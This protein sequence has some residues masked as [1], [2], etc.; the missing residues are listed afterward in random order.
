M[1]Q[2]IKIM[3]S[4]PSLSDDEIRSY[5]DF[6][7][8]LVKQKAIGTKKSLWIKSAISILIIGGVATTSF[9]IINN[10]S[11]KQ[12]SATAID[13]STH[14]VPKDKGEGVQEKK[15]TVKDSVEKEVKSYKPSQ[16]KTLSSESLPK[17]NEEPVVKDNIYTQAEPLN[18]YEDLYSYF[19]KELIYP[20]EA[21]KDSLHGV[22]TVTFV[23]D[24]QGRPGQVEVRHSLGKPFEA[25]AIRLITHMP[26]WKP[27][28]LNGK[29]VASKATIPITFQIEKVASKHQ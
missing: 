9:V 7:S 17:K 16:K 2:K 10:K 19:R 21:L 28:E 12:T 11:E 14:A 6:D 25:E 8:L 3:N 4:K 15:S 22:V 24:V 23:I 1:R 13:S 29:P 26:I 18:G 20:Q 5:M 27:A